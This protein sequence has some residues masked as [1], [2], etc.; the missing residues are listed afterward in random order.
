MT[1]LFK[2]IP[3]N[4]QWQDSLDVNA[5]GFVIKSYLVGTTTPT[6]VSID[7][8]GSV[9]VGT[10]V[11]NADG[12]PTVSGNNV[13]LYTNKNDIRIAIYEN[14]TDAGN[15]TNAFYGPIDIYN[16]S[17]D[18][19]VVKYTGPLSELKALTSIASDTRYLTSGYSSRGDG[20]RGDYYF[21]LGD[22]TTANDG[23][24]IADNAGLGRWFLQH[25]IAIHNVKQFGAT[26]NGTDWTAAAQA[27]HDALPSAGGAIFIPPGD[28]LDNKE[29]LL[30]H[31]VISKSNFLLF[32]A[33]PSSVITKTNSGVVTGTQ[34]IINLMPITS[35]IYN[36]V[37]MDFRI[38][39]PTPN[40][41]GLI[42]GTNN[43]CGILSADVAY[44]FSVNDVLYKNIIIEDMEIA[45]FLLGGSGALIAN[46]R[47]QYLACTARNSRQ[48][49]FNDFS[50]A[51]EDVTYNGCYAV[52]L[53]GFGY[54][55]TSFY[56][57]TITGSVA[58]RTGQSG[59]GIEYNNTISPNHSVT[60]TGCRIEDIKTT[61][62]P[63]SSGISLG[64]AQ[65]PVNTTIS[66]CSIS[67]VGGDGIELGGSPNNISIIGNKILDVG[68][69]GVRTKGINSSGT[70]INMHI[71][72]NTIITN[73]DEY[74]M[75]Q[76]I[77]LSGVGSETNR[78]SNNHI[79]GATQGSIVLNKPSQVFRGLPPYLDRTS[80]GNVGLGEDDLITYELEAY[81][82]PIDLDFIEI[83][84]W[85]TTANNANSKTLKFYFGSTLIYDSTAVE[86][87]NKDWYLAVKII[88]V[89]ANT[90][91]YIVNGQYNAT[92]IDTN[93]AASG[94]Q[95]F[96]TSYTI[97]C[98]GQSGILSASDNDIVQNGLLI[99]FY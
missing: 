70:C 49:G 86:S 24:V 77:S 67:K 4:D 2:S 47:H 16:V 22:S 29:T 1:N 14:S 83:E 76:G 58:T 36:I 37:L 89:S 64:Q 11:L 63:D 55:L 3:L 51:A 73:A 19:D 6:N 45:C 50:G 54:E 17:G 8:N 26:G 40:T 7:Q 97:K 52:D 94:G 39:G 5:E 84:A 79:V 38:K 95:D 69:N 96:T 61:G 42:P 60:I 13:K 62:Y 85:G 20:G 41:G 21:V 56:G 33:G 92:A 44:N 82:L 57:L 43:V 78:I 32:G 46:R 74:T 48:D 18:S 10:A 30:D 23:T 12:V 90:L 88:R 28:Y 27:A 34:A 80:V 25:D 93:Y 53:D 71:E 87:T 31:L 15:N 68:R 75:T 91:E 98:T 66:G 81:K 35:D 9:M 59:I 72:A 99:K 65:D